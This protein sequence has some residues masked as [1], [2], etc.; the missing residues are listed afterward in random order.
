MP[1]LF[2]RVIELVLVGAAEALLYTIVGPQSLHGGQQLLG[3]WFRILHPLDH[4]K[5]HL[6]ID[7]QTKHL[8]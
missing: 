1:L 6:T 3:E 4:I 7:L 2:G 8:H 5:H